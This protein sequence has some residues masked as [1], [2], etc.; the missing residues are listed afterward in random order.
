VPIVLRV[1]WLLPAVGSD[2]GQCEPPVPAQ[3]LSGIC[4]LGTLAAG[5][6]VVLTLPVMADSSIA[7]L[8][9]DTLG[10]VQPRTGD[11]KYPESPV[12]F[13]IV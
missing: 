3:L 7:G 10:D 2:W 6:S 9:I 8:P 12:T 5:G 13:R 1:D 11:L 4:N